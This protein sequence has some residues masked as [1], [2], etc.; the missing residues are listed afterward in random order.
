MAIASLSRQKPTRRHGANRRRK[1]AVTPSSSE[2]PEIRR[3]G[4]E[5]SDARPG[6]RHFAGILLLGAGALLALALVSATRDG[7]NLAG[8]VG[9]FVA[10]EL[11]AGLGLL[12]FA[13][14]V[15]IAALSL[16][17][18]DAFALNL[19]RLRRAAALVVGLLGSFLAV[20]ILWSSAR[21]FGVP[22][23]GEAC[24][25]LASPVVRAL[26]SVGGALAALAVSFACFSLASDFAL[27]RATLKL[28]R[29][30]GHAAAV[31]GKW[32]AQTLHLAWREHREATHDR[33][34]P[35]FDGDEFSRNLDEAVNDE[36]MRR[37]DAALRKSGA[38]L[39]IDGVELV[40]EA[41]VIESI[42]QAME[43]PAILM[44]GEDA[45]IRGKEPKPA[46][47][48]IALTHV[49]PPAPPV[50]AGVKTIPPP[51]YASMES[52]VPQIEPSVL[53]PP[54][55]KKKRGKA[56][57]LSRS[58]GDFNLP[59]LDLL[60]MPPDIQS[61]IDR[62]ALTDTAQRLTQK[63]SDFGI[64]GRVET[65]RPGPVITMYEFVPAPGIRVSKIASLADDLAMAMEAL[66][67]RIVAPIPGKNVVGIEVPNRQRAKVYLREVLEDESFQR[68]TSPLTLAF[69]KD[70][71][72]V[73]YLSDLSRMP[74]LLVAGTTG[75]G[76]SVSMNSMIMSLLFKATPD[77]VRM[78]M[79]DPKM[80]EL[81]MYEG[82]PHLLLPVVQDA[83]KAPLALRWAVEEMERRYHLMGKLRVK[84]LKAYNEKAEKLRRGEI[85]SE[86]V[87]A[88]PKRVLVVDVANGETEEE[89]L[90]RLAEEDRPETI[91]PPSSAS[92]AGQSAAQ[93][94][95]SSDDEL[96]KLPYIVIIIDEL[97]D[98][99]MVASRE[100][101]QCISRLA[102][103]ARAAGIHLVVAT[104]RPSTD[105]VSGVIKSNLPVRIAFRLASRH[106]SATIIN[107][108]G[109]ERLL[110]EGDMLHIPPGGSDPL[111]LHGSWVREN[112]IDRVVHFW[113]EQGTPVYDD[114]IL[115]PRGDGREE[116]GDEVPDEL[117]DQAVLVVSQLERVSISLLQRKMGIGYNRSADLIERLEREG[118]IG[119]ANGIKPREVLV[120]GVG[121]LRA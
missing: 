55:R 38:R 62:N 101:E 68:M 4:F 2:P 19:A 97:A 108:P 111:R 24:Q 43:P 117:Y 33:Q 22:V 95:P 112:E 46:Q 61:E 99:M 15:A 79:I 7:Q 37:S 12:A 74:H 83:Q 45:R 35:G 51:S 63:L 48:P 23:G 73:P 9:T 27:S 36:V 71:E 91:P 21:P 93:S 89:A 121:E 80:V 28:L 34:E 11:L 3:A 86:P 32:L 31:A 94:S 114:E 100:V 8:P 57:Q 40:D 49:V 78:I 44:I 1:A 88:A 84:D 26:S 105:V 102:A 103:K 75:S 52:L 96:E 85:A 5:S 81:S 14:P 29:R 109:A 58:A 67:V 87:D 106:D 90:A 65:I 47:E 98:L 25:A 104:Q 17:L 54:Q 110:G 72:G 107:G 10:R 42:D 20:Q 53:P 6:R 59:P 16:V 69:G 50:D 60:E 116:A 41:D 76:K 119:P 66:Q 56:F 30:F 120:R 18:L 39:S 113:K 70:T 64:K 118:I 77:D 115:K 82:I 92:Q 13:V